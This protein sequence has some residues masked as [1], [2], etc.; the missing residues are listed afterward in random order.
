MVREFIKNILVYVIIL[1]LVLSLIPFGN[2]VASAEK[3]NERNIVKKEP[4]E[5]IKKRTATSKTFDNFDNTYSTE[6]S[7]Q[8]IH[9]K[10]DNGEWK[11]IDNKLIEKKNNKII[12]YKILQM[13]LR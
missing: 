7:Q 4:I 11:E 5:V 1:T 9:F 12:K 13:N 8:P 10:D 2:F 6:I 3:I